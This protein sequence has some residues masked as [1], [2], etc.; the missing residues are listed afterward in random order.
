MKRVSLIVT[1]LFVAA[2]VVL[3]VPA[4]AAV[5]DTPANRVI[6]CGNGKAARVWQELNWGHPA[7]DEEPFLERLA[8]ENPCTK[9]LE[10]SWGESAFGEGDNDFSSVFLAPGKK[11]NW[12]ASQ[13]KRYGADTPAGGPGYTELVGSKQVCAPKSYAFAKRVYRYNDLRPVGDCPGWDP[14]T[15]HSDSLPCDPG[16]DDGRE[17]DATWKLDGKKIIKIAGASECSEPPAETAAVWWRYTGG[18][19]ALVFWPGYSTDLWK[20][21]LAELPTNT[22][23]GKLHFLTNFDDDDYNLVWTGFGDKVGCWSGSG[24]CEWRAG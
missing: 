15:S 14:T 5:P 20:A 16:K 1:G 17:V 2:N 4:E 19:A 12:S 8:A 10:I 23:D 21:E 6:P 9:W 24:G 11:F 18:T 3:A 7:L 13:I 22:V